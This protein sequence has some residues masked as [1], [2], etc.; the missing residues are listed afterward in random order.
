M[1][2]ISCIAN[3]ADDLRPPWGVSSNGTENRDKESRNLFAGCLRS[4]RS[5]RVTLPL[6]DQCHIA[7]RRERFTQ[8]R[9]KRRFQW[10]EVAAD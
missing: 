6:R 2:E 8:T 1:S 4:S 7:S 3:D 9:Q 10:S 5:A